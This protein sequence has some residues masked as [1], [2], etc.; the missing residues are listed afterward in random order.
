MVT[1]TNNTDIV[2]MVDICDLITAHDD[3]LASAHSSGGMK[4]G[5]IRSAGIVNSGKNGNNAPPAA[6][7]VIKA[8]QGS[9]VLSPMATT[10]TVASSNVMSMNNIVMN[11]VSSGQVCQFFSFFSKQFLFFPDNA[12]A[13]GSAHQLKATSQEVFSCEFLGCR[14]A[15]V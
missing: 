8:G 13:W 1:N 14:V 3:F 7:I 15:P 11:K 5:N 4:I 9:P 12:A 6:T 2:M 10:I